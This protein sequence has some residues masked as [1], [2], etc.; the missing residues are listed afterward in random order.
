MD[1]VSLPTSAAKEPGFLDAATHDRGT[2]LSLQFYCAAMNNFGIIT[3][4]KKW[5]SKVWERAAA[6]TLEDVQNE[7]P[8]WHWDGDD[9]HVWLYDVAGQTKA[10]KGHDQQRQAGRLGG[11]KTSAAKSAAARANGLKGNPNLTP[12]SDPQANA[13]SPPSDPQSDPQAEE[14]RREETGGEGT[15]GDSPAHTRELARE[16]ALP[17]GLVDAQTFAKRWCE[18]SATGVAYDGLQVELW[19]ADRERKQWQTSAG[20]IIGSAE[21]AQNDLKFWLLKAKTGQTPSRPGSHAGPGL[22]PR[23][24]KKRGR[25]GPAPAGDA[26]MRR[27][28]G[29]RA[30]HLRTHG[31]ERRSAA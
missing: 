6:V 25:P 5:S 16:G 31:L 27:L 20:Q 12:P 22:G 10:T 17:I 1:F 29:L 11:S 28:E 3:G 2:W 30:Q 21:Q 14:K 9:L 7:S 24:K 4:A 15:G 13:S 8:L 18:S 19:H 23:E 26:S